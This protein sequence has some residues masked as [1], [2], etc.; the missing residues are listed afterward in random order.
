[1]ANLALT[2]RA[3][4]DLAEIQRYS[5]EQWGD[6]VAEEY[7]T[8]IEE[9]LQCLKDNPGLLRSKPGVSDHFSFYRVREHFLICTERKQNIYVLAIRHGSMDLPNRVAELEPLLV[10][11][12]EIL[13]RA[14]LKSRGRSR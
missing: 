13:H 9:A 7:L 6:R 1:M 3:T 4:R 5:I 12:A 10:D 2:R 8:S 11:E 14:F